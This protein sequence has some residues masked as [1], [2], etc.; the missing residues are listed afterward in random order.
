ML[1]EAPRGYHEES[2][3]EKCQ[4]AA[5]IFLPLTKVV[6]VVQ[7]VRV[8]P[9]LWRKAEGVFTSTTYQPPGALPV[10]HFQLHLV[11]PVSSLISTHI[12]IFDCPPVI[13]HKLSHCLVA[14][15]HVLVPG[16]SSILR[17]NLVTLDTL[18]KPNPT[19]PTYIQIYLVHFNPPLLIPIPR[20]LVSQVNVMVSL[21]QVLLNVSCWN[22][23]PPA[24][25]TLATLFCSAGG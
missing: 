22:I 20:E 12:L 10:L 23:V 18:T 2:L 14:G 15:Y 7:E 21:Q 3:K 1:T 5:R 25:A 19:K 9:N 24:L 6:A 16:N 13:C 4:L 17:S 11:R 8:Q